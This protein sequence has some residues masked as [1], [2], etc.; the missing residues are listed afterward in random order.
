MSHS[1]LEIRLFI[2]TLPLIYGQIRDRQ[3]DAR[4]GF[5]RHHNDDLAWL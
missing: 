3:R 2:V 4:A 1:N 5:M